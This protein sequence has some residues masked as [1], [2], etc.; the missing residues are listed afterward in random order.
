MNTQPT[1]IITTVEAVDF[2][3]LAKQNVKKI[4]KIKLS[5]KVFE[6][7]YEYMNIIFDKYEGNPHKLIELIE[8]AKELECYTMSGN[9]IEFMEENY[10]G[11]WQEYK[12][13]KKP[14]MSGGSGGSD[15]R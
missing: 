13:G 14:D 9:L 5:R 1:H 6:K 11:I 3:A 4:V 15:K 2:V 12:D 7:L 10:R 8:V